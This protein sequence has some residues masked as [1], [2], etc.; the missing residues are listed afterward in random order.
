M[1]D[2]ALLGSRPTIS[3][4]SD[5][6]SPSVA[7]ITRNAIVIVTAVHAATVTKPSKLESKLL[8]SA[9]VEESY[10]STRIAIDTRCRC[11]LQIRPTAIVPQIPFIICTATAPT[12][13]ST[14]SYIVKEPYTKADEKSCYETDNDST[15]S[16]LSHHKAA[17]IATS[18]ASEAFRHIDTSGLP[19][20][21]HVKII[22]TTVATAGATVVV[23]KTEP[24]CSTD[25]ACCTVESIPAKP[26]NKYTEC[27]RLE[28][29]VPGMR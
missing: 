12:G 3:S 22:H 14:R 5:T 15:E 18:P 28:G 26:E 2:H 21:I 29:Y 10:N 13:S 27:I 23:R 20:L 19:Y 6:R 7:L 11:L 1:E 8:K 4:S 9:A 25:F 16:S 24:S 17:V